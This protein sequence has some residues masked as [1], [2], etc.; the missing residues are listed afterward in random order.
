MAEAFDPD[1]AAGRSAVAEWEVTARGES[2]TYHVVIDGGTC[3]AGAGPIPSPRI[4]IAF[5]L[6]DFVCFMAAETNAMTAFMAGKMK[7][8]GEVMFGPTLESFFRGG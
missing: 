1:R 7:V 2:H 3:R 6:G 4:T 5:D 8:S